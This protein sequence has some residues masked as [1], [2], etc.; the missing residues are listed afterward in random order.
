MPYQNSSGSPPGYVGFDDG[1][2]LTEKVR[3]KP[4]SVILFDEIEKAH[5]DVFNILLQIL[6]DG[7]LTDAKGRTVNFK[8]CVI[9]MTS[10]IG[11]NDIKKRSMGFKNDEPEKENASEYE[12]MKEV[13]IAELKRSFRPE[14]INRIDDIIVFHK[15]ERKDV[16]KIADLMLHTVA[17][18][19]AERDI[20]LEYTPEAAELLSKEGF[21]EEYGARPLRRVIQQTVED[22]LSEEILEGKIKLGDKVLMT[23]K[24]GK[25]DFVKN[26]EKC[27][28]EKQPAQNE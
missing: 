14:F 19:L 15:L 7:R 17:K 3:R 18:R 9:I 26:D 21:D 25:L 27:G 28:D 23:V 12:Q 11:A 4:Y 16:S 1:G 2:Q 13:M 10:N 8:N 20:Y 24:D 22:K 6:D 5:P